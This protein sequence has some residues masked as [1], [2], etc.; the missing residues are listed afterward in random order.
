M[1]YAI[2]FIF[3]HHYLGK[4]LKFVFCALFDSVGFIKK[5]NSVFRYFS[6]SLQHTPYGSRRCFSQNPFGG[7]TIIE[8]SP[9]TTQSEFAA[10]E[11][12][13]A[14]AKEMT[15]TSTL[16][17]IPRKPLF[18]SNLARAI[19]FSNVIFFTIGLPI[20]RTRAKNNE[21]IDKMFYFR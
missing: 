5:N 6:N 15:G 11:T 21:S 8:S 2:L 13:I 1:H 4:I 10:N 9:N 12:T 14:S 3:V 20:I 18:S 19:S 17:I 16:A 7:G